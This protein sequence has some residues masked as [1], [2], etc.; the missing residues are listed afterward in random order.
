MDA[1]EG[2]YKME[3]ILCLALA[4]LP[5]MIIIWL[6]RGRDKK[7]GRKLLFLGILSVLFACFWE[8]VGDEI[9]LETYGEGTYGYQFIDSFAVTALAEEC[10]KYIIF[11][12]FAFHKGE[13]RYEFCVNGIMIGLGFGLCENL[14]YA[15][16][17]D[18]F[19]MCLRAVMCVPGHAFYG[20]VMGEFLYEA[21]CCGGFLG[22]LRYMTMAYLIPVLQHGLY[23]FCI[24][25]GGDGI[26]LWTLVYNMILYH[27]F[28]KKMK[29]NYGDHLKLTEDKNS[30]HCASLDVFSTSMPCSNKNSFTCA[31]S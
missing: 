23:D 26:L 14:F 10:G 17:G 8:T 12:L 5:G 19:V 21:K 24:G 3:L 18:I 13:S 15:L 7:L 31:T 20:F 30:D 28:V 22:M 29:Q 4:L 25:A 6:C 16:D 27:F 9:I 11:L 2:G 1:F